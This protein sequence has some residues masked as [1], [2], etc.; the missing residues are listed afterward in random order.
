MYSCG[1]IFPSVAVPEV[2][3][4]VD[5]VNTISP[6]IKTEFEN[7]NFFPVLFEY[8]KHVLWMPTRPAETISG[9]RTKKRP[10]KNKIKCCFENWVRCS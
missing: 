9:N 1:R 7:S 4:V 2:A 10:G 8:V 6:Y 5:V 3:P